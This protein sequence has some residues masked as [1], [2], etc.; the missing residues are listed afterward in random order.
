MSFGTAIATVARKYAEFEGRAGL[1]EFWW[2]ILFAALVSAALSSIS[3]V[4]QP[5]GE[6]IGSVLNGVWSIATLVPT[7]AVAVRRLRDGGNRWTQLFWLL[8][9][10]AGLIV[11]ILRLC[12]PSHDVAADRPLP[13]DAPAP[14]I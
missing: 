14:R 4:T 12:D 5:G 1:A 7:L 6:T 9:P 10:I 8:V 11:I 2:W 3:I 13:S